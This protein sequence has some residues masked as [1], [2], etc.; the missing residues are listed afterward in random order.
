MATI[1]WATEARATA[2]GAQPMHDRQSRR[3][4]AAVPGAPARARP[5]RVALMARDAELFGAERALF[6]LALGFAR[7]PDFQPLVTVPREGSLSERCRSHG[8]PVAVVPYAPWT[9]ARR[10]PWVALQRAAAN[11]RAWPQLLQQL[12]HF[13]TDVIYSGTGAI[14]FGALAARRLGVGH[15]WHLQEYHSADHPVAYDLGWPAS[16]VLLRDRASRLV[17]S[18][19]AVCDYYG[20]ILGRDDLAMVYEGF[21]FPP[22]PR[23][24]ADKYQRQVGSAPIV[25]LLTVGALRPGK[26]QDD[27]IMAVTDLIQRGHR[28]QLRI[29]GA[30]DAACEAS[31]RRLVRRHHIEHAVTFLGFVDDLAPLYRQAAVTLLCARAEGFGRAAVESLAHGTPVVGTDAGGLPE[32][33]RAGRTGLLYQPGDWRSASD[34]VQALLRSPELYME[35]AT[36]GLA[37]T[38]QRFPSRRYVREMGELVTEAAV[39]RRPT[40]RAVLS[41]QVTP[42]PCSAAASDLS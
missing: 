36:T 7:W 31:L 4:G 8:I 33:V 22:L 5:L 27:A 32:I 37:W 40:L 15:V 1:N 35:I 20:A 39:A 23:D 2:A 25:D 13:G 24:F 12:R 18:S 29:A 42:E 10:R 38:R 16:R 19:R 34:R 14:P 26:G 17:G 3:D 11:A 6:R 21:D 30:G 41:R 9:S 28:V